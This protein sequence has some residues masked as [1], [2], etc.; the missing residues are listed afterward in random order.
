M[1]TIIKIK[2]LNSGE[3]DQ[4]QAV[5]VRMTFSIRLNYTYV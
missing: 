1:F 5:T 3:G 4:G 2:T